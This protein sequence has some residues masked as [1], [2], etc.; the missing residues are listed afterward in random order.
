M[1]RKYAKDCA[2][3]LAIEGRILYSLFALQYLAMKEIFTGMLRRVAR[4]AAVLAYPDDR[5]PAPP[6]SL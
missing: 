4:T 5:I 3:I 1:L 6:H 2:I